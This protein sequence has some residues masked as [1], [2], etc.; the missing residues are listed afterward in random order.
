[1]T[2]IALVPVGAVERRVL[3]SLAAVLSREYATPC[4]VVD[5]SL[6]PGKTYHPERRQYHSTE[7]LEQLAALRL[8]GRTLG[9]TALDLYIPILTFV[10]GEAQLGGACALVSSHRMSE[11]FYGLPEDPW[12]AENRLGKCAIHEIGHT[13]GLV[14]CD[15]QECVMA[16]AHAVEWIDLKTDRL[17]DT[18]QL[19]AH[20]SM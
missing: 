11:A 13:Y 8:P 9:V 2:P 5:A 14:H 18:C 1:M 16:A 7:L 6:D 20:R 12:L 4:S 10:F 3:G 19:S 17:C 15:D